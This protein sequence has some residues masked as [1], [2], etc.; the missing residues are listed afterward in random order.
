MIKTNIKNECDSNGKLRRFIFGKGN[1]VQNECVATTDSVVKLGDWG[2]PQ[3]AF[4]AR[5]VERRNVAKRVNLSKFTLL[6]NL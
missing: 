3:Q 1:S 5:N 6:A 2:L 4:F